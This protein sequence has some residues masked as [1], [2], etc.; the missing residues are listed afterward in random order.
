MRFNL[1]L[2]LADGTFVFWDSR[3]VCLRGLALFMRLQSTPRRPLTEK[4]YTKPCES[5]DPACFYPFFR[6][7][8]VTSHFSFPEPARTLFQSSTARSIWANE[9]VGRRVARPPNTSTKSS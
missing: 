4:I 8:G 1:N 5:D 7:F 6:S 9:A 3:F 2:F